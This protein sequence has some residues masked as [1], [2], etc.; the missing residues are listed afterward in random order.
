[1]G[2]AGAGRAEEH[3]VVFRDDE[4]QGAKVR[5]GLALE[6]AGAWSKSNSSSDLR[7]GNRA[8]RTSKRAHRPSPNLPGHRI[9]RK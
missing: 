2:L 5:D 1:V 3:H 7:A 9:R 6:A 4:V 8:A